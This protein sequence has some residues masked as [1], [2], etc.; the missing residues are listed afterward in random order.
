[1]S[2]RNSKEIFIKTARNTRYKTIQLPTVN[3]AVSDE[4][5]YVAAI[6]AFNDLPNEYKTLTSNKNSIKAVLHL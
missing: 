1:M 4:S 5:S 6:H 3:E 2:L